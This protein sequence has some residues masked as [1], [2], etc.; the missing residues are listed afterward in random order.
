MTINT[1][2]SAESIFDFIFIF[3]FG[4]FFPNSPCAFKVIRMKSLRPA[5]TLNIFVSLTSKFPEGGYVFHY[6]AFGVSSPSQLSCDV[7]KR[8]IT[9]QAGKQCIFRLFALGGI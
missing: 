8:S 7:N 3:G 2:V 5:P 6:L 1:V 9:L 4:G